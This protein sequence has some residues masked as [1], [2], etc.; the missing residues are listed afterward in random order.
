MNENA[1]KTLEY[2][3]IK[4]RLGEYAL[5]PGAKKLIERLHPSTNVRVID[6]WLAETTEACSI[7]EVNSSIPLAGMEDLEEILPKVVKGAVLNP[8]ELG[9]VKDLL[10]GVRRIRKFMKSMEYTGP[11]ISTYA[12]SMFE[13]CELA[14]EIDRCIKNNQVDD[15]AS[16]ELGRI[17][18]RMQIVEAKTRQKLNSILTGSGTA[19]M[20]QE[21]LISTR[22]GRFVVP[23]K[24]EYKRSFPGSVLDVSASGATLFMEPAAVNHLQSEYRLLQNEEEREVFR[25]LTS[26]SEAV[27]LHSRELGINKEVME[28]YDFVFAK[29][30]YG[31]AIKGIPALINTRN[32]VR[33][34]GGLHPLLGDEGVPLDVEMGAGYRALIITGPNTGGKTVALKTVGLLTLMAQSGLHI[35]AQEGTEMAVFA[36]VCT[37]IGDSQSIEQS[38]S[39]FS[40]HVQNIARIINCADPYTLV[41]LDELGAGTDPGEGMGFAIAV[42]EEIFARGASIIA[43]T[44]IS[45]IKEFANNTPGFENGS[46]AFDLASLQPLYRLVVGKAGESHAF[47]IALR[48]GVDRSIVSRAH[49]ITYKEK[50]DY[51]DEEVAPIKT[52][53][54]IKILPDHRQGVEEMK[55]QQVR[56]ERSARQPQ[57]PV[58]PFEKGDRVYISTMHRTGIVCEPVNS[59][60]EV[61][62]MVMKKKYRINHKRLSLHIEATDLYPEDYD[63]DIVLE[64]KENRKKRKLMHKRHVEG[65]IIEIPP[66]D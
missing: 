14:E 52:N 31:R 35:P 18:K 63:L 29:A 26:L 11:R 57:T 21:P 7:L 45:E 17:R 61:V 33:L 24:K 54:D 23:V 16:S 49:E 36:D 41:L 51:A 64:S 65:N 30:R 39:T 59:R 42:L 56:E 22:G 1:I 60:G 13:C 8:G 9:A 4:E 12:L 48:L 46:M 38:L 19:S 40:G 47:L 2:D 43:T 25:V 5:S 27:A 62:V 50:K 15:R 32:L 66:E 34:K 37:D 10:I 28:H 53:A 55:D 44:H 6:E 58:A 20:L 3:K